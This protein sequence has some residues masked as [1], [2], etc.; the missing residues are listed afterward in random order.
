MGEYLYEE[1]TRKI[2]GAAFDVHNA[3]GKGLSEKAYENALVLRRGRWGF[4]LNSRNLLRF[5]FKISEL[6]IKRSTFLLRKR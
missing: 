2:I 4:L 5:P 6:A 1:I 3:L